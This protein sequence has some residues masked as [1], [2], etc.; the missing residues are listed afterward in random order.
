MNPIPSPRRDRPAL[1]LERLAELVSSETTRAGAVSSFRK[2]REV[3]G[4]FWRLY[5]AGWMGLMFG[6]IPISHLAL[7]FAGLWFKLH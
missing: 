7:G 5:F 3:S 6:P 1:Q 2:P 4:G